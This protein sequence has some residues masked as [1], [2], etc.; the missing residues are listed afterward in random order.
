MAPGD[1]ETVRSLVNTWWIPNDTREPRD[2]LEQWLD[3]HDV[4]VSDRGLMRKLRDELRVAIESPDQLDSVVNRLIR[5][6]AIAPGVSDSNLVFSSDGTHAGILATVLLEAVA[7]GTI[8]RLKACPD[9][10]WAFFDNTRNGGK[11]WC[12]M[13]AT[14]PDG[15]GCGNIAKARRHRQRMRRFDQNTKSNRD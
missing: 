8:D 3:E 10:R 15:R 13:N 7:A 14:T 1:L 6:H 11:R 4:L 5:R 12:V 9:C 2:D